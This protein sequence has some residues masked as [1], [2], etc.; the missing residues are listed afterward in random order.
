LIVSANYIQAFESAT[1]KSIWKTT[2]DQGFVMHA[3]VSPDGKWIALVQ[4]RDSGRL[5]IV[6]TESGKIAHD[7]PR[8]GNSPTDVAFTHDGKAVS[9]ST[10]NQ[11]EGLRSWSVETGK[12]LPPLKEVSQALSIAYSP[13]GRWLALGH[14]QPA[15]SL[16][17]LKTKTVK[18]PFGG[19]TSGMRWLEF[20]PDSKRLLA[21][22]TSGGISVLDP[23]AG[24]ELR[25]V[26]SGTSQAMPVISADSQ[27][28]ITCFGNVIDAWNVETGEPIHPFEGHRSVV[29]QVTTSPDGQLAATIGQDNTLRLWEPASGKQLH[30]QRRPVY[31][32]YSLAFSPDGEHL[33][34]ANTVSSIEFLDV[35]VLLKR[36]LAATAQARELR[37]N[38]FGMFVISDDGRTVLANNSAGGGAQIWDLTQKNATVTQAPPTFGAQSV[39]FAFSPDARYS[40]TQFSV[41]GSG[42]QV[43]IAD[44]A[45]SREITRL[46]ASEK[47]PTLQGIF[48]G[49][50]L[51]ASRSRSQVALWDV[52]SGKTVANSSVS[53]A[54]VTTTAITCS[55]DGRLLAWAES[56]PARTIRLYDSLNNRE[57]GKF[58]GHS[59]PVQFLR[60]Q[61]QGDRPVL[62][63]ASQDST[64]LVWDLRQVMNRIRQSTPQ[65][66][67]QSADRVW[68]DL[69][70]EDAT[71]MHRASWLLTA[72]GAD[73]VPLLNERLKPAPIDPALGEKIEKLVA[74][75]DDDQFSVREQASQQAAELGE[76]AEPLLQQAL[77]TTQSA[78]ARH[79]IRRI[80]ADIAGKP[81]VL[82]SEQQR[83]IRAVQILEQIG[84]ADSRE[85]LRRLTE[86]QPSA[87]L[88]HEAKNAMSRLDERASKG[89]GSAR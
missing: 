66:S 79:R 81:L 28:V 68:A 37:G 65:L 54:S 59:G 25:K 14:T 9:V 10:H 58:T 29:V 56:D 13:D 46:V 53:N 63:S 22:H 2:L 20:T 12:E 50:R 40:A 34:W 73:A 47:Q 31:A 1:K 62:L 36:K 27:T 72:A 52:L 11:T 32:A 35:A 88:T 76:A 16:Y 43:V 18:Q 80:L 8:A 44:V 61:T 49:G 51:F 4:T 55:A 21:L 89:Y 86:G 48:A 33:L 87:R 70:A 75:M 67:S 5:V 77:K 7:I 17:D 41:D 30:V 3:A 19:F 42:R 6:S 85:V 45:R 26:A 24:K 69:G 83:A 23:E 71:A 60:I 15:I 84:G 39:P 78:E 82:S 57:L 64:T 38:Q 74:Q